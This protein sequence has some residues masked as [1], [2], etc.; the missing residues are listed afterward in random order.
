[1]RGGYYRRNVEVGWGTWLSYTSG[2]PVREVSMGRRAT[3]PL[4]AHMVPLY[5]LE[6]GTF[7]PE[8]VYFHLSEN[9]HCILAELEKGSLLKSVVEF[10]I[11][12][13]KIS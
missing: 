7:F 12:N 8:I 11:I 5:K 2:A 10:V 9:Y 1:M 6:K 13:V 4:L 3:G